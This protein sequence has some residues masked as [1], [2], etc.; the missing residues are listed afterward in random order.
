MSKQYVLRFSRLLWIV[1]ILLGFAAISWTAVAS[2]FAG[3]V[4]L[5][6]LSRSL[7]RA[8]QLQ[9]SP[10]GDLDLMRA[11]QWL[12]AAIQI[13][14]ANAGAWRGQG[15][16][17]AAQG[18]EQE[19]LA[20]WQTAGMT[21]REFIQQGETARLA[22]HYPEALVWYERAEKSDPS[23]LSS[24]LY[25]RSLAQL[26][27]GYTD[28]AYDSLHRAI[29]ADQGWINA[30]IR[31]R[32]WYAWGVWLFEQH[33][34]VEAEQAFHTAISVLPN[35][36]MLWTML[37]E[38]YRFLGLAQWA[39]N[40]LDEAANSLK[41]AVQFD[42]QNIWAH[43]HYGKVLYLQSAEHLHETENEFAAALRLAPKNADVWQNLIEFWHWVKEPGQADAIC[44]QA[45]AGGVTLN[46]AEVCP[47]Q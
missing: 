5:L 47:A 38:T 29:T 42:R 41:T 39:Q 18:R 21:G 16:N 36:S 46:L 22:G 37:S 35:D 6:I 10:Q 43:I 9:Q 40:R 2:S 45:R 15:V 32:A 24:V 13:N 28:S 31:F 33:Q 30:E 25:Y 44:L 19:A 23:L 17:L 1:V 26:T 34:N 7:A 20:A 11:Q 8:D 12:Q 27:L 4:G 14:A 3:N